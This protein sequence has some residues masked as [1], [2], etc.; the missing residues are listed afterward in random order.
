MRAN[1]RCSREARVRESYSEGADIHAESC[2]MGMQDDSR[3]EPITEGPER[4]HSSSKPLH[5][6]REEQ[7]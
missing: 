3:A 7:S 5:Y 6:D 2:R 4:A 1:I